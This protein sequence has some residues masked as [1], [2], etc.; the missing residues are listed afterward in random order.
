MQVRRPMHS[1]QKGSCGK[2]MQ[3][4]AASYAFPGRESSSTLLLECPGHS[5]VLTRAPEGNV[6]TVSPQIKAAFLLQL[7]SSV[8]EPENEDSGY[9]AEGPQ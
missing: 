3:G 4:K 8:A 9:Q 7:P 5:S 1:V 2:S 6:H